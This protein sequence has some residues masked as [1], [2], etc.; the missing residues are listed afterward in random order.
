M[1]VKAFEI[2]KERWTTLKLS[3]GMMVRLRPE[4]VWA[5]ETEQGNR[6]GT[7]KTNLTMGALTP[8]N[9]R[10]TPTPE[11]TAV[12][13]RKPSRVYSD[14]DWVIEERGE[15]LYRFLD[16]SL[17]ELSLHLQSLRR[18]DVYDKAGEPVV[19]AQTIIYVLGQADF[20]RPVVSSRPGVGAVGV[21]TKK[22]RT[23]VASE[24]RLRRK[25]AAPKES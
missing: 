1:K 10:S 12:E 11:G 17:L 15:S 3:D 13:N 19:Q 18:Y 7:I 6:Q 21:T 22:A 25:R 23:V 5:T 2:L 20:Q 8:E 16:G 4:L 14:R 9:L 24:P